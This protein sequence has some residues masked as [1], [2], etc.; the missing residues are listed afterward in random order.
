MIIGPR[1]IVRGIDP[2]DVRLAPTPARR[3][4]WAAA[5]QF[6]AQAKEAELKAGLDRFGNPMAAL[7]KRTVENRH[8]EMGPADPFAPPLQPA[9]GLSRTRSLFSTQPTAALDGVTCWW[10]YDALTGES[11]GEMLAK[12]RAGGVHLPRRDVIGLS[13]QSL[14]DV[15]AKA[16][17]WW[18]AFVRTSGAEPIPTPVP[19]LLPTPTPKFLIE[20]VPKYEP[21]HPEN[22][23]PKS[24]RRISQIKVNGHIY[25]MQSGSAAQVR[26]M[27]ANKSFSGW[28]R[29]TPL[30]DSG[31]TGWR[32]NLP[33]GTKGLQYL[34]PSDT[35]TP[36]A[37]K[38]TVLGKPAELRSALKQ[39][40]PGVRVSQLP[41]LVGASGEAKVQALAMT[42]GG[43]Y[44]KAVARD[45][46]AR[47]HIK[48]QVVKITQ[49][50]VPPERQ[51]KGIGG[52]IMRSIIRAAQKAGMKELLLTAGR[53]DDEI[54]YLVWPKL[55]FDGPIP[56]AI[57]AKL[58]KSL[59]GARTILDLYKT[60][61]G[62]AWWEQHGV[63]VEL[64]LQLK[65]AMQ[66]GS[67]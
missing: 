36:I 40:A 55:G 10:A 38:L 7:A 9:H 1:F 4:F 51:A 3:A 5:S 13:L 16:A 49:L 2:P 54:G 45:Y 31:P 58:P 50:D 53:S 15:R 14:A 43:V 42:R 22:A 61:A 17:A 41:A 52:G 30:P 65:G 62:R 33:A 57:V 6:V 59:R 64:S 21:K 19:E 25:T 48:D 46:E 37:P 32:A 20:R 66:S 8:S 24:P 28:G 35:A 67:T 44:V 29:V 23:I 47:I 26:R 11:W 60:A 63:T 12:H 39:A 18:V 56:A 34:K 27:V